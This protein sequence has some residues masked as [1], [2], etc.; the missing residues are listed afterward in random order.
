MYNRYGG[1]YAGEYSS[2]YGRRQLQKGEESSLPSGKSPPQMQ[3]EVLRRPQQMM[4][5]MPHLLP[6]PYFSPPP[7]YYGNYYGYPAMPRPFPPPPMPW[8]NRAPWTGRYFAGNS[9]K[10]TA[11]ES[12]N[13]VEDEDQGVEQMEGEY[14]DMSVE[15]DNQ[16]ES[17]E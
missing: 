16:E 5:P 7:A 13:S 6:Q 10:P 8:V 11:S 14:M 15:E 2:T 4:M 1:M 17:Q 12:D 9:D 3:E